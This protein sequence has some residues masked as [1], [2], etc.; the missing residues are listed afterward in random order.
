MLKFFLEIKENCPHKPK[1]GSETELSEIRLALATGFCILLVLVVSKHNPPDMFV[2]YMYR[3]GCCE[4][5]YYQIAY[6]IKIYVVL[7]NVDLF[8]YMFIVN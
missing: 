7:E 4:F 2:L 6:Q 1:A 5:I 3:C 8:M